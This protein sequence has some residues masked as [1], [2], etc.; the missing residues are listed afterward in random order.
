MQYG[1][2]VDALDVVVGAVESYLAERSAPMR[3]RDA[4]DGEQDSSGSIENPADETLSLA[5][6]RHASPQPGIQ[7]KTATRRIEG[8]EEHQYSEEEV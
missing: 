1:R 3:W 6:R 5:D 8:E 2:H 7:A 4:A